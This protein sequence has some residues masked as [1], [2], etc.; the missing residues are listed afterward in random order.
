MAKYRANNPEYRIKA[1]VK[2]LTPSQL[3]R[4]RKSNLKYALKKYKETHPEAQSREEMWETKRNNFLN[5]Y[6]WEELKINLSSCHKRIL[7]LYYGLD[8]YEPVKSQT[9]LA[10]ILKISRQSINVLINRYK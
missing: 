9:K 8:G 10:K 6:S 2:N 3:E 5:H 7:Q 4:R 1:H